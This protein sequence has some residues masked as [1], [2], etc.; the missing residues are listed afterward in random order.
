MLTTHQLPCLSQFEGGAAVLAVTL[1]YLQVP[2]LEWGWFTKGD[3]GDLLVQVDRSINYLMTT[4][5]SL[6][7][8]LVQILIYYYSKCCE[9]LVEHVSNWIDCCPRRIFDSKTQRHI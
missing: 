6:F 4:D 8:F 3:H 9:I 1:P 2:S 5:V 7:A